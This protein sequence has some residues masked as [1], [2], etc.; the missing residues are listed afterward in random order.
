MGERTPAGVTRTQ[1]RASAG[2]M[3][4]ISLTSRGFKSYHSGS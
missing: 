2:K 3:L 1:Q 4:S